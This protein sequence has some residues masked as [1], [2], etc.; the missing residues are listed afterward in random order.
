V[1]S[2]SFYVLG[3]N[4][5]NSD[6]S[7]AWGFVPASDLIGRASFAIWPLSRFGALL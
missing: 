7:R 5:G 3:D 6:D 1:P 4:R 2:G